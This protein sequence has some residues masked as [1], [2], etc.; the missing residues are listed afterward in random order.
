MIRITQYRSLARVTEHQRRI[1]RGLGLGRIGKTREIQDNPCM[2]GM[3]EK[4]PHL[5]RIEQK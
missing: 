4:V 3:L 1:V 2:R 5:I